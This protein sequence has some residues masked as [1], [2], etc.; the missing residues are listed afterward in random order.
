MKFRTFI[1]EEVDGK[2]LVHHGE[3][4][5]HFDMCPSAL[6]AFHQNQEDGLGDK[7]GFHEA[8]IAVDQY[9]GYEKML[10]KKGSAT[11][12]NVKHMDDL[13]NAA[14]QAIADADLPGH[15]YHQIHI[16]A[17]K[18]LAGIKEAEYQGREVKLNKPMPGDVK[19]SK[20]FVKDPATGNVKKVNFGDKNMKIKKNIPARRKSFRARHN[21]DDPGPKTK[22]RYWS[23]KAW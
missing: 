22:P 4:T 19:K 14:K 21:C 18:R 15:T 10:E 2:Q 6:K 8:V 7:D 13:V 20:V 23:C 11:E 17:V 5:K 12:E 16:D 3:K 1:K 9:L